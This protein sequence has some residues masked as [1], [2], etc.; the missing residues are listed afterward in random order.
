MARI[1]D[2][3]N[4]GAVTSSTTFTVEKLITIFV[5]ALSGD[6]LNHVI[7]VEI[8]SDNTN[9][10]PVNNSITGVGCTT[11]ICAANYVRPIVL[12]TE[13]KTSTVSVDIIGR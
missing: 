6:H 1:L 8:S 3:N 9:W 5:Y 11:L 7:G 4:K 2:T 10:V 12:E 13:G